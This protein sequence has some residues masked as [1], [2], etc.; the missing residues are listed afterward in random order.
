VVFMIMR[1]MRNR[2]TGF[3]P[4]DMVDIDPATCASVETALE[5]PIEHSFY[6]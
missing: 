1:L 6:S 4:E 5:C 3:Q 2:G